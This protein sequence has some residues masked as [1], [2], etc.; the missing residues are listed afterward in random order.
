M[1]A[2]WMDRYLQAFQRSLANV[3]ALPQLAVLGLLSGVATGLVILLF[4]AAIELPLAYFLPDNDAENF[5][6][7][8]IWTRTLLPLAGAFWIGLLLHYLS[9]PQRRFGINLVIERL[10]FHQGYISLRSALHQ[11]AL[12]VLT[13]VSGQSGGREGPAV[14]LGA[15]CSSLLGQWMHLPNNSIRTL[16][17]CGSAAAISASFNT[18]IAGVVFAM[19]VVLMEYSISG[20]TPVIIAAVSATVISQLIYGDAPAF[21]VPTLSL[22]SLLELPYIILMGLVFA[23]CSAV[24]VYI[25][26]QAMRAGRRP[27]LLRILVAGAITALVAVFLPE[28]LG[29]GYDSVSASIAGELSLGLLIAIGLTKMVVTPL[30]V[31]LGMPSG[32]IGPTLFVG[33]SLGAAMGMAGHWFA[34]ETASPIGLYALLGMGAMMGAVLQAPLS[35]LLAV[36]ELT[37]S[38]EIILP[39]MLIIV[40]ASLVSAHFFR[41]Q[42]VFLTTLAAQG[43][44]VTSTPLSQ[45]LRR[46]GVG[47]IM[48]RNFRRC[49]ADLTQIEAK[50]LLADAPKWLIVER[51]EGPLFLLPASDLARYLEELPAAE[52]DQESHSIDLCE[53]PAHR[54]DLLPLP[55][56]S[57]LEEA[58]RKL[59]ATGVEALYVERVSAPMIKPIIGIVTR[60]QIEGYYHLKRS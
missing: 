36:I 14:H 34:P 59:D 41:Q 30:T 57:T 52:P 5:E 26:R 40:V 17:A 29:I 51:K 12:G 19:E 21:V 48:D 45:T 2:Q 1:R 23:V 33:A 22:N 46:V 39:A 38:T 4:R 20:F 28:V 55:M 10:N 3:D 15:A 24:F 13:L 27:V 11:F 35:A 42:S 32:V 53:I 56:Q 9:A 25:L 8:G 50:G 18:P 54:R 44:Q 7:L 37:R 31:G 58:L 49:G 60:S 43:L 16:V 6:A 47:A